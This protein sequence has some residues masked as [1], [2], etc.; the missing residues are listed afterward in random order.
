[1]LFVFFLCSHVRIILATKGKESHILATK[2]K[3][4]HLPCAR[5]EL[6][7]FV[8]KKFTTVLNRNLKTK[9]KNHTYLAQATY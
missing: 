8:K 2:R 7:V 1:M 3:K 4:S 5:H 6:A 9:E